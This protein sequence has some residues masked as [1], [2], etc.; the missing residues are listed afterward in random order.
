MAG[1]ADLNG[2]RIG[3]D[4]RLKVVI[5]DAAFLPFERARPGGEMVVGGGVM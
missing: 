3:S 2:W 5:A 4:R 1:K